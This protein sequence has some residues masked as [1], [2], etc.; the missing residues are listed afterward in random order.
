ML[1]SAWPMPVVSTS[2]R[3]NPTERT[4]AI[5]SAIAA[6]SEDFQSQLES[7]VAEAQGDEPYCLNERPSL[8]GNYASYRVEM[9]VADARTALARK[10]LLGDLPGIYALLGVGDPICASS[11]RAAAPSWRTA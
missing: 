8:K 2:T 4:S 11:S 7:T 9:H 5:A 3:S 10:D 6:L 1:E